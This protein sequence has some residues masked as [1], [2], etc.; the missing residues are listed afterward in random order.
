MA[1]DPIQQLLE[2]AA[3]H[4]Q[5]GR[6]REAET[7]Y[8][9][10]LAA[11]AQDAEVVRRLAAVC[12]QL[13]RA[14]DAVDLMDA[15]AAQRPDAA[16][17][18]SD[19]GVML[20]ALG[21][22]D[23]A[24]AAYRRAL[25]LRGDYPEALNNLGNALQATAHLDEAVAAFRAAIALRS[26]FVE[27]HYNL[28]NALRI[29]GRAGEGIAAY[30]AAVALRPHFA[31]A[32]Y[33]L[34][35]LLA[36]QGRTDEAIG[37]Y[38]Q[39]A[40][41]QP[42][43]ADAHNNLGVAL[44]AA[45]QWNEAIE[46]YRQS[47]VLRP[48]SAEAHNNLGAALHQKGQLDA[49]A[50]SYHQ[51]LA[52]RP[53]YADA[54]SNLGIT[55]QYA[56]QLDEAIACFRRASA[57][58]ADARI[59]SNLLYAIHFHPDYGFREIFEAH[60]A[61]NEAF[62][63]LLARDIKPHENDRDPAR[64]LRIGYVSPDFREHPVGRFLL[65]LFAHHDPEQVEIFCYSGVA[66]PDHVTER[67]RAAAHAWRDTAALSDERLA[68]LIR[69]DR[70]DILVDLTMH[71]EGGRLL[72]FARRPAPVQATY[73]AYC[74]TTGLET[75][76]YRLTDV[77]LDP[78][79]RD[80]RWY[81][82][83]SVR[84]PRTYWCYPP[85]DDARAVEP[86]PPLQRR[87]QQ[88]TFGCLNNFNKVSQ[89]ALQTWA[90]LLRALPNS[91]LILYA[92]EGAHR[93]RTRGELAQAG[94]NPDRLEFIG[95]LP[96]HRYFEQYQ[97]IDIALD[98]FPYP[99]G[100]TTCDALWMGVPVVSLAGETAVSRAGVSILTNIGMPELV[101]S[102]REQYVQIARELAGDRARLS[103]LRTS[104]RARMQASP[105]MDASQ[106]ARDVE[107]AFRQMWRNWAQR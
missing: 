73:L 99:G 105:L 23:E 32:W 96:M 38:E 61:W 21:R 90:E 65:P 57:L 106:F 67:L 25:A 24:I 74:S 88:I 55:L 37:A 36:A 91:R 70:I 48:Q 17:Y 100:T 104:L 101:A 13:G 71:M 85:P 92:L 1:G 66:Y 80:D 39:A 62:A 22:W 49:A 93:E 59:A 64:R 31:E 12:F 60:A 11:G 98:P 79:G 6:L 102:S 20:A 94:I 27:V 9:Q 46:H 54:L 81:S 51:A 40:A 45:G 77:H 8:R 107:S 63:R 86:V 84:L 35:L 5:A 3:R 75:I 43:S 14:A 76:D 44:A 68:E 103:E 10:A 95:R 56:G 26:N 41:L 69:G 42:E 83:R 18:H 50:A 97:Q 78:Q 30:R 29:S 15:A 28:G 33:F 16:D 72:A 34:G 2:A 7:M 82:E 58:K 52:A 19:R 4:H 87:G 89:P 53:D 47:L